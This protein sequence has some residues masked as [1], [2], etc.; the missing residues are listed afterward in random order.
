ATRVV[1][2]G[3]QPVISMNLG[4][5]WS[6]V[7]DPIPRRREGFSPAIVQHHANGN[8]LLMEVSIGYGY[9]LESANA[10]TADESAQVITHGLYTGGPYAF[11]GIVDFATDGGCAV[12]WRHTTDMG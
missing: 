9:Y 3:L 5:T 11:N 12:M 6:A 8:V 10:I 1:P 7:A 4:R 2:E